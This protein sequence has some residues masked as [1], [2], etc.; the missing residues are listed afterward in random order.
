MEDAKVGASVVVTLIPNTASSLPVA[1][2]T[3][4]AGLPE[5]V[6]SNPMTLGQCEDCPK[7]TA[8]ILQFVPPPKTETVEVEVNTDDISSEKEKVT[9]WYIQVVLYGLLVAFVLAMVGIGWSTYTG[10]D[11]QMPE[12][13]LKVLKALKDIVLAIAEILKA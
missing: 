6:E 9:D 1:P 11:L 8:Q 13:S 5:F 3:D 10:K 7:R 12:W 2:A 4:E